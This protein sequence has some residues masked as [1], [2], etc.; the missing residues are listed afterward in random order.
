MTQP[1]LELPTRHHGVLHREEPQET[2]LAATA[3]PVVV[4]AGPSTVRGTTT[5]ARKP[6]VQSTTTTKPTHARADMKRELRRDN[7]P[8]CWDDRPH[9][10][11]R[12]TTSVARPARDVPGG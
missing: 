7:I 5:P 9:G 1:R 3:N 12:G 4:R 6:T 11:R 10:R 2:R 8:P